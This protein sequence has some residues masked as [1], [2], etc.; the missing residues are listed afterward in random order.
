[1]Q[2]VERLG[3]DV[4][5]VGDRVARKCSEMGRPVVIGT[6]RKAFLGQE[7]AGPDEPPLPPNERL[8]GTA[9][10]VTASLNPTVRTIRSRITKAMTDIN[11]RPASRLR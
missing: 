3:E 9:A 2:N 11:L 8:L 1:V 10:T 5:V 6:S 7:L 4:V